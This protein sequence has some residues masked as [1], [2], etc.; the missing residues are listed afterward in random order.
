MLRPFLEAYRIVADHL[1]RQQ[2]EEI[3]EARFV[4]ECMGLGRQYRLQRRIRSSASISKVLFNTALKLAENR[5][6]L[7]SRES[8]LAAWR[9][10]FATEIREAIRR[11]EAIDALAASRRAGLT[12]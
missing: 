7:R 11:S 8:D 3:D 4:Q 10:A 9:A 1:E 12:D 5:D 6:L 2:A